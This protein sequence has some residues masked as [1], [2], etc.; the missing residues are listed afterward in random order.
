[1]TN[2]IIGYARVQKRVLRLGRY[3]QGSDM[4]LENSV[5]VVTGGA[6][7]LGR[8]TVA[9]FVASGAKVAI[10]DFNDAA[11]TALATQLG[12]SVLFIKVNVAD[13]ASVQGA[14]AKTVERFGA[15]HICVNYAGMGS[16]SR[17]LSKKGVFP[18]EEFD[19]VLKVNL[20]GTFNVLR[21]AAEQMAKNEA[22]DGERGV[23][24]NTASIAAYEG[25]IGQAAYSASK[26]GVVGMTLPIA[27]D[28]ASYGI[29]VNTIVPGLI[30]TPLFDTLEPKVFAS[31]AASVLNPQ[32]LGRP[33][34]IAH[35]A[36][37]I[38][39]NAYVNG[40]CIRVDGGIR[41]QPR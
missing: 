32:R 26:G 31:L 38:V 15:I 25:Q 6:S 19:K 30:H 13:E 20:Y 33:E 35:A 18:L 39:E 16:A 4:K 11:G 34:E 22:V 8:A 17:T 9:K 24:I 23:I 2:T 36:A 12:D 41:M 3:Q 1:V 10:F 21:F 5:A 37:F 40:E 27:R 7:G 28:L 29:R 14:I